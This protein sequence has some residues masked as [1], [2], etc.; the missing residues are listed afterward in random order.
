VRL[1]QGEQRLPGPPRF[2]PIID[3]RIL[4]FGILGLFVFGGFFL[5]VLLLAGG[6]P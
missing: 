5:V 6:M 2:E 1:P 3:P 4:G